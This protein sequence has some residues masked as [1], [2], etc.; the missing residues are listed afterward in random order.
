[1]LGSQ[2]AE[3]SG[4]DAAYVTRSR[5]AVKPRPSE[6]PA[7]IGTTHVCETANSSSNTGNDASASRKRPSLLKKSK[8]SLKSVRRLVPKLGLRLRAASEG[9]LGWI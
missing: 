4:F 6:I 7:R 8:G 5:P 1:M 9:N 2:G 3:R